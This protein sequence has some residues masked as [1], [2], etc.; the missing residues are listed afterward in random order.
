M[1]IYYLDK[2]TQLSASMPF[3]ACTKK[4]G[5]NCLQ[6]LTLYKS[7]ASGRCAL[8]PKRYFT[9]R[10]IKYLKYFDR[11]WF[12]FSLDVLSSGMTNAIF[13]IVL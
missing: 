10:L 9:W 11:H 7:Y 8:L 13:L 12:D 6:A 1:K 4:D 3:I 5:L 2:I